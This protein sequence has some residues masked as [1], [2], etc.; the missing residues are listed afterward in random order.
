MSLLLTASPYVNEEGGGRKDGKRMSTLRTKKK[1]YP[2]PPDSEEPLP[3]YS[4]YTENNSLLDPYTSFQKITDSPFPAFSSIS[5]S[6]GG[7]NSLESST[8]GKGDLINNII[9][10]VKN[11]TPVVASSFYRNT[12][13]QE[14]KLASALNKLFGKKESS[15]N[16]SV[17]EGM[18]N[19]QALDA[20]EDSPSLTINDISNPLQN[21][22]VYNTNVVKAEASHQIPTQPFSPLP[23]EYLHS[24]VY[25]SPYSNY[26]LGYTAN[27]IPPELAAYSYPG[28]MSSNKGKKFSEQPILEPMIDDSQALLLEKINYMIYLLEQQKQTKTKHTT[29]EFV[30][31]SFFGVFMIYIV[32][33][34]ARSGRYIR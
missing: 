9:P 22:R 25:E 28:T 21:V 26:E 14:T 7:M 3:M 24:S 11:S 10:E 17:L 30:L 15:S 27:I 12:P 2:K 19:Y 1:N 31:Y 8:N 5:D 18:T 33:S 23:T 20:P 4:S 34:F 32:D 13:T 6:S 29:E 16:S